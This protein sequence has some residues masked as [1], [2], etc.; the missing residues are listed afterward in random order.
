MKVY[1]EALEDVLETGH[2][3]EDRT[4]TGTISKFGMQQR[5]DLRKGFPA[6]TTKRLAW[7]AV[8]S[9]LLWFLEGSSTLR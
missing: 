9:E 8:V 4:G 2:K 1:L 3:K 7:K 5:Y 6:M